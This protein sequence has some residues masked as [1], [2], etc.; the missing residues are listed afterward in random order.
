MRPSSHWQ[1]VASVPPE[2]RAEHAEETKAAG[3]KVSTSTVRLPARA[4]VVT[5]LTTALGLPLYLLLMLETAA[6]MPGP[7]VH[8]VHGEPWVLTGQ[9]RTVLER[10][11]RRRCIGTAWLTL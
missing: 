4:L 9:K 2:V 1:Q 10:R 3:G 8:P 6:S 7:V 5:G 11:S